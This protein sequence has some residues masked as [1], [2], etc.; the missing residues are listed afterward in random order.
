M[1]VQ[2]A[3]FKIKQLQLEGLRQ[4]GYVALAH[5]MP[6]VPIDKGTLRRSGKVETGTDDVELVFGGSGSGAEEYAAYQYSTAKR[7]LTSGD[8]M[9]RIL[10]AAP[11]DVKRKVKGKANSARYAAAYEHAVEAGILTTFP[12]GARWYEIILKDPTIQRRMAQAYAGS[13]R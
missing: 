6:L 5:V 4:A 3:F 11:P 7:H 8:A 13:M 10:E 9:A 1:N 12:N 2:E